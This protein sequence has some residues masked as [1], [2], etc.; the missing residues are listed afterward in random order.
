MGLPF[1]AIGAYP[2]PGC[3]VFTMGGL[4]VGLPASIAGARTARERSKREVVGQPHPPRLYP[5]RLALGLLVRLIVRKR[6]QT[7]NVWCLVHIVYI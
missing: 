7:A 2:L 1:G 5:H 4:D 6:M 3:G